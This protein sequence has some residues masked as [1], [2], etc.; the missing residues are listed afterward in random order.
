VRR[1]VINGN[2]LFV[3]DSDSENN[4]FANS[5]S[6]YEKYFLSIPI[7]TPTPKNFVFATPMQFTS[8]EPATA[9]S[10]EFFEIFSWLKQEKKW[11]VLL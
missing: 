5:D 4:F 7:P 2:T 9:A 1:T 6:N 11:V 10:S 8:T 3:S